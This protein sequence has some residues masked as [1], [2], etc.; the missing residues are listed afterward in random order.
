MWEVIYIQAFFAVGSY[1]GFHMPSTHTCQFK[2][3]LHRSLVGWVERIPSNPRKIREN[4]VRPYTPH[5]TET[6]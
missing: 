1:V 3:K 2:K 4:E 5:Q 6:E